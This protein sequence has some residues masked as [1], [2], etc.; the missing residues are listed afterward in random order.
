MTYR[1]IQWG[2]GN[3]GRHAL[4]TIIERP[5]FELAGVRVYNPRKVGVDA[6]ALIAAPD[7]G[8]LATDDPE[9][10]LATAADCVCYTALGSTLPDHEAP[11][12]DICRLLAAGKNV[13]SSAVEHHAYLLPDFQLKAA[14]TDALARL[15]AACEQG[16]STFFHVGVNPGFTMDLWPFTMSRL[17]RRIDRLTATEVVDM[18]GYT[19]THMVRDVMGFGL[20]PDAKV[21]LDAFIGDVNESAFVVS[22]RILADA[23]GVQLENVR[24]EREVA[25]TEKP[26]T[27]AAGLLDAGTVAATRFSFV[28]AWQGRD[29]FRLEFVWRVSD[30][31]APQW[32]TGRSRW[33]LSVKGDPDIDSEI[34]LSTTEDSGRATS[35]A[36]ATL[37]L[38]AV[39]T[40]CAAPPGLLN[41]L[42][43]PQ[44]GGGY[45]LV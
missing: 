4:R 24:Y 6:G 5:D 21:L 7:T 3:V 22:M 34:V 13:V 35:L 41:N 40:V 1:V 29:V 37:L 8:V 26:V 36:V 44:H 19:S 42:T 43:L 28:G 30:D 25:V 18:S 38:N 9:R 20:P 15:T 12:A 2:T 32:P 23:I 17:S 16:G 27:I 31:V 33:L 39:P 11:L 45:F 14:G 10:I